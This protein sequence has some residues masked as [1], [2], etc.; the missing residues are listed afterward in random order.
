[1]ADSKHCTIW[2]LLI[3]DFRLKELAVKNAKRGTTAKDLL[4]GLR[5]RTVTRSGSMPFHGQTSHQPNPRISTRNVEE[6]F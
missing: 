3:S 5:Y 6:N 4:S 1:M 2:T